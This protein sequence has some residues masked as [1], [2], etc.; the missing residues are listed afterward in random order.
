MTDVA[1]PET[2]SV[3]G[4]ETLVEPVALKEIIASYVPA[5]RA[6]VAT[7]KVTEPLPDPDAG[8]TVSQAAVLDAVQVSV[9]LPTLLIPRV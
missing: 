9:P 6:P 5:V 4:T 2:S 1:V 8:L 3:T 7:V